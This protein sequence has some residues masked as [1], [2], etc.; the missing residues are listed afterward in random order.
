MFY[1]VRSSWVL[2]ES[3]VTLFFFHNVRTVSE[4]EKNQGTEKLLFYLLIHKN[5]EIHIY[6]N[7][8]TVKICSRKHLN[9]G[10]KKGKRN[11][12]SLKLLRKKMKFTVNQTRPEI[13]LQNLSLYYNLNCIL[14][15]YCF[16]GTL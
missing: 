15:F 8:R 7:H 3:S 9:L 2:N 4:R 6:N 16:T 11:M 5:K 14:L 13:R 10:L 12:Y 1:K